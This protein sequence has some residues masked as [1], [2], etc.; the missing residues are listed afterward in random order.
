VK[1]EGKVLLDVGTEQT[2]YQTNFVEMQI[3]SVKFLSDPIPVAARSTASVYGSS[4]AAITV[5]NPA[6]GLDVCLL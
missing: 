1:Y 2:L 3:R 5:S 6:G 4:L